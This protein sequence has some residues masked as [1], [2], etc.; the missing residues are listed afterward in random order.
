[1]TLSRRSL[2]L[3]PFTAA[4]APAFTIQRDIPLQ[5]ASPEFCWF[6]PRVAAIPGM[7]NGA[8]PRVLMTLSQHLD[9]DDHYSGLW[10]MTSDD[11]GNSWTTPQAPPELAARDEGGGL[12]SSVHDVT[13]GWHAPT[14]KIIAVGARTFYRPD[15]KHISNDIHRG[16]T[17]YAVYHPATSSWNPWKQLDF[18]DLPIFANCRSACAQWLVTR[19]GRILLP[20]YFQKVG[21]PFDAVT[22]IE[23]AF[24]GERLTYLRH[25]DI[26]SDDTRRGL[27]EPS[28]IWQA[29]TYYLTIR[30]DDYAYVTRSRDGL[31]WEPLKRW[32]FDDGSELGSFNTQQHWLAHQD[33]LFLCYTSRRPYNR[34][35]PRARAPL[36]IAAVDTRRLCVVR[37]TEQVL[38]P[39]R[40][41]MLGNFGA[42]PIT[43]QQSWVTDAE[44]LWYRAGFKPT[45]AGGNGSVWIARVKWAKP[46]QLLG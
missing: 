32:T 26:L 44:F 17:A 1:M 28:I 2:L 3:A 15:G 43:P 24:D 18:P 31:T 35:I 39:E 36:F 38:I 25:G 21:T 5:H 42:A 46:N 6:H 10:Y 29:G 8:S 33:G 34:H 40:G 14:G 23:C 22:V 20:A 37:A 9:A 4:A 27:A 7:G 30:H 45:A 11:L 16:G 19:N 41:L 12:H 13:P